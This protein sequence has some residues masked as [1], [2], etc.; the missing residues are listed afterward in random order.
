MKKHIRVVKKHFIVL[1]HKVMSLRTSPYYSKCDELEQFWHKI[2]DKNGIKNIEKNIQKSNLGE[3]RWRTN[4][5]PQ[6]RK[7]NKY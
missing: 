6:K 3:K 5:T 1:F 2:I 7:K 4:I